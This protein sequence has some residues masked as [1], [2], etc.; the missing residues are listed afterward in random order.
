MKVLRNVF[1]EKTIMNVVGQWLWFGSAKCLEK[2]IN[3]V[4]HFRKLI[5]NMILGDEKRVFY[6]GLLAPA[7]NNTNIPV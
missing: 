6:L 5:S 2:K 1:E 4:Q 7:S 3:N